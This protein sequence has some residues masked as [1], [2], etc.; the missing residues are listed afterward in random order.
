MG[1]GIRLQKRR[2]PLFY[3]RLNHEKQIGTFP[4]NT[5]NSLIIVIAICRAIRF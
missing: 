4:T 1:F 3:K 2:V 5:L